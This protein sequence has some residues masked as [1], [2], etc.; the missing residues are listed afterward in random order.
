MLYTMSKSD[1]CKDGVSKRSEARLVPKVVGIIVKHLDNIGARHKEPWDQ[2]VGAKVDER[3]KLDLK[4]R[5]D[6]PCEA[7]PR[8]CSERLPDETADRE[9][10][11]VSARVQNENLFFKKVYKNQ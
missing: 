2:A 11:A 1:F 5:R 8:H 9:S 3:C 6:L 4:Q 10:L 7:H